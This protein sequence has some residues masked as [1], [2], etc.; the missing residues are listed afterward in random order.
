MPTAMFDKYNAAMDEAIGKSDKMQA[1]LNDIA[2]SNRMNEQA[3]E[4]DANVTKLASTIKE[5]NSVEMDLFKTDKDSAEAKTLIAKLEKLKQVKGELETSLSG[6]DL[7]D[8]QIEKI[9]QATEKAASNMQILKDKVE[10]AKSELAKNV[11]LDFENGNLN[12]QLANIRSRFTDLRNPTDELIASYREFEYAQQQVANELIKEEKN[13]DDIVAAYERYEAAVK[14]VGNQIS[15]AKIAQ[16]DDDAKNRLE[17]NKSNFLNKIVIWET[18]N[19]AAVKGTSNAV[20]DF[21]ARIE[22][23]KEAVAN[24][25]SAKLSNLQTQFNTVT[26]EVQ[27]AGKTGLSWGDAL[28]KKIKQY[29]SYFTTAFS[30]MEVIQGLR[31]MYQAVLEVDTAMTELKRVTDLSANQ[32]TDLYSE[33]TVSAR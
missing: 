7:S 3:K 9:S 10:D 12:K 11:E 31:N 17:L 19:S 8:S 30:F 25:D 16:D 24:A 29:S 20:K 22:G 5:I 26:K 18:Q 6:K 14:K 1:E 23:I 32:Y 4:I 21:K 33:L 2:V 15:V 27:I 28:W 13:I